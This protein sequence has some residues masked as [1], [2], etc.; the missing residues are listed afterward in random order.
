MLLPKVYVS[1]MSPEI[2]EA[3]HK[4]G[5][6]GFTATR[7]QVGEP[8]SYLYESSALLTATGVH[9]IRDHGGSNFLSYKEDAEN[10][11]TILHVDT[12]K[13]PETIMEDVYAACLIME[14]IH[15][16]YPWV[17]FE[18]GTEE[19]VCP[20]DT[21]ILEL[22]LTIMEDQLSITAFE[23]IE[24][25]VIQGG[26]KV[27]NASNID[28]NEPQFV[29]M[30]SVVK[31]FGRKSKEHNCDFL[32]KAD[33]KHRLDM[34]LDSYNIGPEIVFQQNKRIMEDM[35]HCELERLQEY[36]TNQNEWQRWTD[37]PELIVPSTLHYYAKNLLLP[38][39]D[40][41]DVIKE[42]IR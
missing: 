27:F 13:G 9:C 11:Y 30:C 3:V 26:A 17:K 42:I 37:K 24:Y 8:S 2:V 25:V 31:K 18:V 5:D 15:G 39:I 35:N 1:P 22:I 33:L 6:I 29:D 4:A 38:S 7:H 32:A 40:M 28:F 12:F 34:G 10:A 21:A 19:K 41:T 14:H 20:Y 23:A 16:P 36:C